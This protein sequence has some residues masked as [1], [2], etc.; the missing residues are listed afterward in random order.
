MNF[1]RRFNFN[2]S[3]YLINEL[4][5]EDVDSLQELCER[6]VDYY[7]IVEG[8]DPTENTGYDILT[9]LPPNKE[10]KDKHVLGVYD[11]NSSLISIIDIVKDYKAEREWALGLM[12]IDPI[13]RGKG[14]GRK[15]HNLILEMIVEYQAESIRIGVVEENKNA[16]SFWKKLGYKE[17]D[18][19]T[20]E[21]GT[22]EN[23]VI[24]MKYNIAN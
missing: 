12:L 10:M 7:E 22:K 11:N 15:L 16:L 5:L 24:V 8:R 13:L 4:T 2:N 21:L 9:E 6:C 17:I 14:L 19:V 18:R 23:T 1:T 3:E 20:M